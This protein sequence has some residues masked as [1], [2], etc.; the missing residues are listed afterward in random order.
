MMAFFLGLVLWG[1]TAIAQAGSGS[2]GSSAWISCGG[3]NAPVLNVSYVPDV[4]DVGIAG[5]FWMGVLS[6]DQASG[7]VMTEHGWAN[8]QGGLFPFAARYDSALP[9]TLSKT[10]GLPVSGYTTAGYVGFVVY[11]GHGV[12]SADAKAKVRERRT[13]LNS[14]RADLIAAGKWTTDY[15][16]DDR[17]IWTLVLKDMTDRNKYGAVLTVPFVDCTPGGSG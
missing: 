4:R 3:D 13:V 2:A 7:A 12:Y 16:S 6:P 8:Y 9:R 5:L 14:I 15:D 17:Y 11:V 10:Y 1:V